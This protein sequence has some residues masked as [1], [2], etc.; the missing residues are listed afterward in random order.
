MSFLDSWLG[1]KTKRSF[2]IYTNDALKPENSQVSLDQFA[3]ITF[4]A[5]GALQ[6]EQNN[7][8]TVHPLENA[9]FSS[10]SVEGTS[11]IVRIVA[12][13]APVVETVGTTNAEM[14]AKINR[15]T[16]QLTEYQNN[17]TL[18]TIIQNKPLFEQYESI[19]I[20]GFRYE[21]N[22]NNTTLVAN[23]TLQQVRVTN[24][25]PSGKITTVQVDNPEYASTVDNGIQQTN[26]LV[27]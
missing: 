21:I 6:F 16:Q 9:Q 27:A 18:L 5:L 8:I 23:L 7:R 15:V 11:Y 14:R 2:T 13:Y 1:D 3:A 20:V 26:T 24:T 17:T 4:Q 22:A 25:A 19:K 10:D 12:L